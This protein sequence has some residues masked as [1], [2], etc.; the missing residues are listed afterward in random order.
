[1]TGFITGYK[2]SVKVS[3][4]MVCMVIQIFSSDDNLPGEI[5]HTGA[6]NE[7]RQSLVFVDGVK[8][9]CDTCRKGDYMK[10]VCDID[11]P[12]TTTCIRC[13]Y[14]TYTDLPNLRESCMP[15]VRCDYAKHMVV[16][17]PGS[18]IRNYVCECQPGFYELKSRICK[19]WTECPRGNGVLIP[20][21]S[22]SDIVCHVCPRGTFANEFDKTPKCLE[23]TNCESQ[24]LLT[25]KN[26]TSVSDA[27][28]QSPT[29]T[30]PSPEIPSSSSVLPLKTHDSSKLTMTT[31]VLVVCILAVIITVTIVIAFVRWRS[32]GSS[33]NTQQHS[34]LTQETSDSELYTCPRSDASIAGTDYLPVGAEASTYPPMEP[35]SKLSRKFGH[36]RTSEGTDWYESGYPTSSKPVQFGCIKHAKTHSMEQSQ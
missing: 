21:N 6:E 25:L 26:G 3:Y 23:H 15:L 32:S 4:I 22:T 16:K 5:C 28:C 36:A 14:G 29:L 2:T 11:K 24:G 19:Q 8:R 34:K 10:K 12:H 13:H 17:I 20:G 27:I 9:C 7:Y 35:L 31:L 33:G 18:R 1:M 30:T